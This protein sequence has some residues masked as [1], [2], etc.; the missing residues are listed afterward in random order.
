MTN[1]RRTSKVLVALGIG[2]LTLAIAAPA[3][4][5]F[6]GTDLFIP[7]ISRSPGLYGSLWYSTVWIYNPNQTGVTAHLYYLPR[8]PN[9]TGVTPVDVTIGAG[10]TKMLENIVESLF[11]QSNSNGALRIVCDSKVV[12]SARTFAKASAGA[13]PAQTFGQDFAAVPASFAIGLNESTEILGGYQTFPDASSIARFNIG[14]VEVTGHSVT[15]RW[16]VYDS[17][18]VEKDHYDKPVSAY[19]QAQGAYKDYFTTNKPSLTNARLVAKVISGTGR[20]VCY[21]SLVDNDTAGTPPVQDPTTFEMTYP[22]SALMTPHLTGLFHGA[23]WSTDG[24]VVE[25]GGEF[26]LSN[27]GV[28]SYSA[29]AGLQC[30]DALYTLDFGDTPASPVAID[31][32]GNFTLSIIIG[33]ED[34]GATVFTTTWTVNGN[35]SS[36]GVLTGTIRSDTTGGT[37]DWAACNG[38]NIVRNFRA[39]WTQDPT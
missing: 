36:D 7:F 23:V 24:L 25:G 30:G 28:V 34:G 20:V 21:G 18:G 38:T 9:N 6:A 2:V 13:P 37:G 19:S 8:G 26:E 15:V 14:C 39:A 22:E 10:E 16:T 17:L 3:I 4:A 31:G 35:R 5:G 33:Y 32:S 27:Q 12:A 1:V 29:S 11:G